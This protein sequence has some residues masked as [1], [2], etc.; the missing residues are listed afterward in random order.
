MT[1]IV[2]RVGVFSLSNTP[3][4]K[5]S[6]PY[7]WLAKEFEIHFFNADIDSSLLLKNRFNF[8]V[9]IGNYNLFK[10]AK[11]SG[12]PCLLLDSKDQID[13][14]K[15]Y[16][17]Y[18]SSVLKDYN[19]TVSIFTPLYNTF[20]K[21]HRTYKSVIKQSFDDWEW[22]LL[23]DSPDNKN[24]EYIENIIKDDQRIKL[25]K[26]NRRDSFVGSTKRQAASLC[27][28]KYLLEL[29]HDDELHHQALDYMVAAF[30]KFPDAGF[31]YSNSCEV[32]ETGGNV[33]Y[34][35]HF[36]MG[37]GMHYPF[38]YKGR[39]LLGAD[40]PIN[41]STVRHIVGVPNHFRCWERDTYFK[42]HRHNNK[43][44]VVDDYELL[45]RTFL[46]TRMIHV[47]E[48]LYIQYMNSGGNNTQ[49]PRRAEIQRLVDYI[50]KKYDNLIHK[51]ILELGGKDWLW[52]DKLNKSELHRPSPKERSTLAYVYKI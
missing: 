33:D 16:D 46:L 24:K 48:V 22:I 47:P 10:S 7:N 1:P 42:I 43:L 45:V 8:I 50:Q 36:A 38:K 12:L 41:A 51:R 30:K 28:G 6:I 29:D 25:Y 49:E 4:F 20:E 27:N 18:I 19:P 11:R 15:I 52:D 9:C 23:D 32:F 26:S 34:G 21:F 17:F 35:N 5:T 2:P 39:N 44:A 13:G 37:Y 14:D 31:C 40:T 3:T